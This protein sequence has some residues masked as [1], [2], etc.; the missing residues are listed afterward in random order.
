MECN[1]QV[2]VSICG[3]PVTCVHITCVTHDTY[4]YNFNLQDIKVCFFMYSDFRGDYSREEVMLI[5]I[6]L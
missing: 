6:A 4:L 2:L 1:W 3:L 5:N